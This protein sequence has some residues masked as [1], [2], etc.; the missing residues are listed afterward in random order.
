[1]TNANKMMKSPN[2]IK[3]RY[4]GSLLIQLSNHLSRVFKINDIVEGL[5]LK[6]RTNV[7]IIEMV[8]FLSSYKF[9]LQFLFLANRL[10][11][12]IGSN[13]SSKKGL[14]RVRSIL[15]ARESCTN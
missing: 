11:F 4:H 15:M 3:N 9:D 1:M 8:S 7:W 10:T 14:K 2:N 13:C 5:K 6:S 12:I